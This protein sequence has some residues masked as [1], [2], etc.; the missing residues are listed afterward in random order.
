MNPH[1][2]DAQF[3]MEEQIRTNRLRYN[4]D[5]PTVSALDTAIISNGLVVAL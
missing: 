1:R 2:R 3:V 5:A 4:I